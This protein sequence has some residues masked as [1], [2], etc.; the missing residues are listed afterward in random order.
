MKKKIEFLHY[1]KDNKEILFTLK[2][3]KLLTLLYFWYFLATIVFLIVFINSHNPSDLFF[4][5]LSLTF[6][7]FL[8]RYR[9]KL[10]LKV[11]SQNISNIKEYA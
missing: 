2:L 8:A 1:E 9:K 3:I 6:V 7:Y 10:L 4:T 5:I 11:E